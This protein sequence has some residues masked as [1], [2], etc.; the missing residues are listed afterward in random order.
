MAD[1]RGLTLAPTTIAEKPSPGQDNSADAGGGAEKTEKRVG[2]YRTKKGRRGVA[3]E[4]AESAAQP[5]TDFAAYLEVQA[6]QEQRARAHWME[7][8]V[9]TYATGETVHRALYK[10]TSTVHALKLVLQEVLEFAPPVIDKDN[11]FEVP[12]RPGQV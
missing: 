11:G 1:D 6:D 9:Q 8:T 12:L 5:G 7:V 4:S 10:P 3:N 2:K